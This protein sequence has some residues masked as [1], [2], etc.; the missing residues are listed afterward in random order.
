MYRTSENRGKG[1]IKNL[2]SM[3]N[4]RVVRNFV[5]SK[6]R[7]FFGK[8][9]WENFPRSPKFFY[10]TGEKFE[11]EGNATEGWTPLIIG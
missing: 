3:T 7:I 6:S 1:E 10:E 4:K 5:G 9:K 2:W 8:G 11:T